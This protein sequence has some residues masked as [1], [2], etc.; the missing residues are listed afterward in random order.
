MWGLT[1]F[2]AAPLLLLVVN[3]TLLL[4]MLVVLVLLLGVA[5]DGRQYV[6]HRQDSNLRCGSS[7]GSSSNNSIMWVSQQGDA[8][9][10]R[11]QDTCLAQATK[12]KPPR[13]K[14]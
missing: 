8:G 13:L 4:L 12:S 2:A 11:N 6:T 3:V 9:A 1:A 10:G 14:K 5:V 7:G